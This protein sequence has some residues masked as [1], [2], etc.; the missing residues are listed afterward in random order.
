[1]EDFESFSKRNGEDYGGVLKNKY[2]KNI[3]ILELTYSNENKIN[4]F[5]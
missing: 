3:L 1:M 4:N 5:L 2:I